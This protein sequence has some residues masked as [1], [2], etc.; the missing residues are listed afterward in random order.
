MDAYKKCLVLDLDNTLWGGLAGEDGVNGVQLSLEYPGNAYLALQQA[1]LD[2]HQRGVILA[3]NSRNNPEDA[4]AVIRSHPNML[5][6]EHHFAAS[7]F[8]WEDKAE[9]IRSL[10]EELNIGVDSMVFLDDDPTNRA[11][12]RAMHPSVLVPELPEDPATYAQILNSLGVFPESATTDEDAMRG[13]LYVTERLRR[14]EEDRHVSKEAFLASLGLTLTIREDDPSTLARLSQMTGKTNQFNID[15]KPY[16]PEEVHTF[17]EREDYRVFS[18]K[19]SDRFGDYGIIAL[20][21]ARADGETWRIENML[22][23]C[24]AFGRGIEEAFLAHIAKRAQKEGVSRI[25][26][27]FVKSEKNAPAEE[28]VQK[29][30]DHGELVPTRAPEIPPWVK[31][32]A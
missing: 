19:L 22:V 5:L 14:A 2:H 32:D 3:I 6:K 9:N 24:R 26:I 29:Y 21:I 16:T 23:S 28:F 30:F 18:A 17:M 1:V 13:N 27:S 15:K 31:I 12:V 25:M 4:L 7:R 10:A 8:N 11:L 20:A